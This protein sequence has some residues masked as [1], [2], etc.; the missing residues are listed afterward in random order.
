MIITILWE[1]YYGI[2][3]AFVEK[4]PDHFVMES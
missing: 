2:W 1:L 4:S 3:K